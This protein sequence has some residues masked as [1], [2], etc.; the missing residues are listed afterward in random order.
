MDTYAEAEE[1]ITGDMMLDKENHGVAEFLD[2]IAPYM[3]H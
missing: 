1:Y 3:K 2:F